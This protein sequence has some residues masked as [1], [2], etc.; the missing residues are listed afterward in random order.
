LGLSLER[1]PRRS[2]RG[3]SPAIEECRA[4]ADYSLWLAFD[5]GVEGHVYLGDLVGF[6]D[7]RAWQD[8]ERF[9]E[10]SIDP[11]TGAVQWEDGIR[12]DPMALYRDLVG[13]LRAS[14]H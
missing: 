2:G 1:M 9:L 10:V 14:L 5:D 8:V 13:R 6:H 12:L 7:F 3:F 11:Q 4:E